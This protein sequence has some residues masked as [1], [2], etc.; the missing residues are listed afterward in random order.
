MNPSEM[1]KLPQA[2][3]D[4]RKQNRLPPI[5]LLWSD[6]DPLV[7]PAFGEKYKAMLPEAEL[8]WVSNASHFLHVDAPEASIREIL[9]FGAA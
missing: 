3:S 7:P 9:R 4:M 6:W 2:V 8:V 1:K 5:R